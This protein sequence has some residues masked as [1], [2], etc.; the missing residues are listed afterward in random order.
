MDPATISLLIGGASALTGGALTAFG[1][2]QKETKLQKQRRKLIDDLLYS[3]Q[4][5]QGKYA[6]LYKWDEDVFNK[7]FVEPAKAKF[8]NQIAPQIQQSYI[9]SGNQYDTAMEDQLLRAGVDLDQLLNQYMYQSQQDVKN[10]KSNILGGIASGSEAPYQTSTGQD[11]ASAAGGFLSSDKFTDIVN[12]F[13]NKYGTPSS[14]NQLGSA[15]ARRGYT[16]D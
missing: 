14:N 3:V 6:D 4:T 15:G 8:R 13:A 2:K 7:S 5:G 1:N 16:Q 12:N 10:R 9:N 11:L